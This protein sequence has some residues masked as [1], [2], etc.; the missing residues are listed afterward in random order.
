[1]VFLIFRMLIIDYK[2]KIIISII[3]K[4][5]IILYI[6]FKWFTQMAY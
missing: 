6:Y 2:K 1:M 4:K 5:Y 3:T